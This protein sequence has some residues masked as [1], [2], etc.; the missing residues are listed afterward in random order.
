MLAW[1]A[2]LGVAVPRYGSVAE[3]VAGAH[4]EPGV[5][6]R[7]VVYT[8]PRAHRGEGKVLLGADEALAR[9]PRAPATEYIAPMEAAGGPV[10]M[11]A[12]GLG[13]IVYW[14]R[15]TSDDAW[16]SN[17]GEVTVER[18]DAPPVG[19]DV[20]ALSRIPHPLYAVDYAPG[21]GGAMWAV[22]FNTAPQVRGT[23]IEDHLSAR[24]AAEQIIDALH[25]ASGAKCRIYPTS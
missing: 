12:L 14:L 8:E 3:V 2:S 10:S 18:L 5:E 6:A 17:C 23:G 21:R 20:A 7:V 13:S 19:V 24:D 11:R 16:R 15:Y 25:S 22:D 1:M 4:A 9:F